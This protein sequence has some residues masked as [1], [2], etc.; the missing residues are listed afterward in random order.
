VIAAIPGSNPGRGGSFWI[1]S[2]LDV[3]PPGE[4]SGWVSEPFE[5]RIE[6][7][8]LYGRGVE[9]NQQG[10]VSSVIAA[11]ALMNRGIT[12]SR[13]IKLLFVADEETGSVF[14]I[15]HLL[16][17]SD[18]FKEGDVFLVPDAGNSEG[19]MIEIAEK[20]AL[21][22]K[23]I[24]QGKQ[25]HAST[26]DRGVNAFIAGSALV[27]RMKN[28]QKLFPQENNLFNPSFS[29]FS[30]TKKER[31]VPNINTIPGEDVFYMD[32]RIIPA[33]DTNDVLDLIRKE[34]SAVESEYGVTIK[35]EIIHRVES[36]PTPEDSVIVQR[37]KESL[38]SLRQ[39]EGKPTGIGGGTV[40]AY[41]RNAGY[42][43]VVWATLDSAAHQENEYCRLSNLIED[44]KIMAEL[45][46]RL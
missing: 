38:K 45:M 22:L 10:L 36:S 23:F 42:D 37:L 40:A 28:L 3:V 27:L 20:N 16:K 19:T 25:V 32:C 4:M 30:P 21:W 39:K 29:T 35:H 24:V 31:N 1:M 18:L 12:P 14:G 33:V 26:P 44:A 11:K 41:L 15:Q 8:R 43:T 7:D 2:H 6:D 34:E 9:D 46:V 5:L 13:D 17:E